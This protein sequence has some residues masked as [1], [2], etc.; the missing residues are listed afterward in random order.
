MEKLQAPLA[1]LARLMLVFIF[2][3]EGWEKIG[4]YQ[5]NIWRATAC[6]GRCCRW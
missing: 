5:G 4:N 3:V 6:R 1:L 2:I